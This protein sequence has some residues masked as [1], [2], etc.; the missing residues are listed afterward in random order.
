[1]TRAITSMR[2]FVVLAAFG[3]L[4]ACASPAP[5]GLNFER[6]N[7]EQKQPASPNTFRG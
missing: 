4:A 6:M 2:F 5:G 1:M 7:F 3:A